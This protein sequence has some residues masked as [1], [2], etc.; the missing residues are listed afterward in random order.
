VKGTNKPNILNT[1]AFGEWKA[2]P[3]K[4]IENLSTIAKIT[5]YQTIQLNPTKIAYLSLV[6]IRRIIVET[7][8]HQSQDNGH[9]GWG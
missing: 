7:A 4:R 6:A 1:A 3:K 8:Q 5:R 2:S 9:Q